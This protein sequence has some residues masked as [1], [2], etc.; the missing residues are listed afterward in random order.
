MRCVRAREGQRTVYKRFSWVIFRVQLHALQS[1]GC[2]AK[3]TRHFSFVAS[4]LKEDVR[5]KIGSPMS[6]RK[7]RT[8]AKKWYAEARKWENLPCRKRSGVRNVRREENCK[9]FFCKCLVHKLL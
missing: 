8:P 2:V 5:A 9:N 7:K 4:A 3:H 6:P 1:L